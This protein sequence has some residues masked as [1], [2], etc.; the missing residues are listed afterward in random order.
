MSKLLSRL[1]RFS[2][3]HRWAVIG[4][5]L[6]VFAALVGALIVG[7]SR[8]T[9]SE[10]EMVMPETAASLTLEKMGEEFPSDGPET[11]SLQLVFSPKNGNVTG[12]DTA[13]QIQGVLADATSLP[14]VLN[15]SNPLDSE[16]PHISKDMTIAVS[17]LTYESDLSAD[18]EIEY[19]NAALAFQKTAPKTLGVELGGNLVPLG[20]PAPGIG[21]GLG[22]V[23]AAIVLALTFGSILA[24][25]ANLLI[26]I[27]GVGIGLIGILAFSSFIPVG[28]Y[29]IILA[30]MLGL[31]VGIDYSLF[32]LSRFKTELRAGR[33]V[34]NAIARATG[35]AGTAIVFA[36]L[37][38]ITA[39]VAMLIANLT[40]ITEMGLAAA[41]AVF[42]AVLLALTLLPAIMSFI[43]TRILTKKQKAALANGELVTE[44]TAPKRGFVRS[45]GNTV[46]KHPVVSLLA[47]IIVLVVIAF[48]MTDMK[49]AFNVPGGANPDSTERT[50]YNKILDEF[51]GI[52]SPLIVLAEGKDIGMRTTEIQDELST[53]DGVQNVISGEANAAGTYARIV[54]I[55]DHG[56]I[57]DATKDLVTE[58]RD[59][60]NQIDGV[61]LEVTGETAIGIDQDAQLM[62]ALIKY[63]VVITII[64]LILLIV[65]FRSI[66]IPII[67]TFGYLLS[68]CAAFGASVAIFQWGWLSQVI[69]AP[70]GDPMLSILPILLVGVLF[71]LAM[72]YQVFLVSRIQEMYQNGREPKQAIR[73]GFA[74]SGPVLLATASI[75]AVVFAGFATSSFAVA[76]A[77]AFGLLIGVAA[78]AFIVRMVLMPAAMSLLGRSAWWIPKW[79]DRILPKVDVEGSS[80]ESAGPDNDFVTVS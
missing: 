33:T 32:I 37:T 39:L 63:V 69:A 9:D 7:S 12:L 55:P 53:L 18:Q 48:P 26:A 1:G 22:V 47:G 2:A 68:L 54:L 59:N 31:A 52:Q 38:V 64:S 45:W 14:G 10:V 58:I 40:F 65:L 56:P 49:T 35:T 79:L 28:D 50:A 71:G 21:E 76:A 25:G 34:R 19:Y 11:R 20:A 62:K 60:A 46:V 61:H 36:G 80:L 13:G 77:I 67:A 73:E 51:G 41:F 70:Q 43:G 4:V 42:V 57:D 6:L 30:A 24:A 16:H 5:W 66:L 15:V 23:I 3:K 8:D 27:F 44:E 75:M 78:D 74:R 17:T 72:D 29:T